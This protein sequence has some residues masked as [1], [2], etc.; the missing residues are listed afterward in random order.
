VQFGGRVLRACC[1]N[2][3]LVV[4][5]VEGALE[6]AQIAK[7][8]A[9]IL[10]DTIGGRLLNALDTRIVKLPDPVWDLAS[11]I[12][13]ANAKGEAQVFLRGA[14]REGSTWRRVERPILTLLRNATIVPR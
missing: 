6:A 2:D 1:S 12:F 5:S 13:S 11:A 3:S 10:A 4:Y 14:I 9:Q 7:G 8:E